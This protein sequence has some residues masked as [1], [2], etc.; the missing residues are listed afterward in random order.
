VAFE[1]GEVKQ[2]TVRLEEAVVPAAMQAG[3]EPVF[4]L[5]NDQAFT[6]TANLWGVTNNSRHE[7]NRVV[8]LRKP[9]VSRAP[10][11]E[12]PGVGR[13]RAQFAR[14]ASFRTGRAPHDGPR[15]QERQLARR[16][17][18]WRY[19][20]PPGPAGTRWSTRACA[21]TEHGRAYS[22]AGSRPVAS[23]PGAPG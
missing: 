11:D 10:V 12:S 22:S 18:G 16:A 7:S 14:T 8:L 3:L 13:P 20:T 15:P 19:A 4:V 21:W 6:K 1:V 2:G 9:G 17:V 5:I 23:A